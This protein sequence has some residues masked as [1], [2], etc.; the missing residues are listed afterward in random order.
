MYRI[1]PID[2]ALVA[3]VRRTRTAPSNGHPAYAVDAKSPH[4]SRHEWLAF[5][6]YDK[7]GQLV[8]DGRSLDGDPDWVLARLFEEPRVDYVQVHSLS[9]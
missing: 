7:D 2:P 4:W 8:T 5:Y 9:S 3:E 1:K 6:A